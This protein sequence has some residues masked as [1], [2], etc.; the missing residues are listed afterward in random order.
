MQPRRSRRLKR[1]SMVN[2]NI[3]PYIDVMLVLLVIFMIT[4]PVLQQGVDVNLPKA[5][6]QK[7]APKPEKPIVVTV[8]ASGQLYLNDAK[9]PLS[10]DQLAQKIKQ[11]MGQTSEKT[12]YV[13]GDASAKYGDVVA[14][15]ASLQR[16]GV[17]K[18]GLVTDAPNS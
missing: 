15:M 13:R 17:T 12:V 4:T 1:Q 6:A 8:D 18:I 5:Q 3:V 9:Q 16:S 7:V 10:V 2:I 14:A 11:N